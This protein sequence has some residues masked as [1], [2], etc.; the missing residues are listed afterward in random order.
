MRFILIFVALVGA[1]VLV[2][3]GVDFLRHGGKN[4]SAR[5]CAMMADGVITN[6]CD[7]PV[8]YAYCA[9]E[10]VL[11]VSRPC[12]QMGQIPPGATGQLEER[13]AAEEARFL[14]CRDPY[15]PTRARRQEKSNRYHYACGPGDSVLRLTE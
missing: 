12:Y 4:A 5:D 9:N 6:T 7:E 13:P 3:E 15:R 14:A 1:I 10:N 11:E 8:N 2:A